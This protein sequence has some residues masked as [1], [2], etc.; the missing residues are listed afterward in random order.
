MNI[1]YLLVGGIETPG[2]R[3]RVLTY[4][5]FFEKYN[6]GYSCKYA[7]IR[8]VGK[9]GNLEHFLTLLK[10]GWQ[11]DIVYNYRVLLSHKELLTL[12]SASEN[13]IFDFDDAIFAIPPF[14]VPQTFTKSE[15]QRR[16]RETL[17]TSR[18][19]IAG[20]NFLKDYAEQYTKNVV[21]IPTCVDTN[22]YK[23]KE[24]IAECKPA[25][26]EAGREV[27]IGW[28]G[29]SAN[30]YYLNSISDAL[31]EIGKR[32]KN[33]ALKIVSD[34]FIDIP[35]IKVIKKN[36]QLEDEIRDLHSF[37]IGIMP[38]SEDTWS[39]GKCAFKAIQCMA[40]GL[41]VV[42]SRIGMNKEVIQ[43]GENGFL[44][45]EK[46]EWV[47]KLSYLIENYELRISMGQKARETVENKYSKNVGLGLLLNAF[48]SILPDSR[49]V[50]PIEGILSSVK[51]VERAKLKFAKFALRDDDISYFTKPS[52]LESLYKNIWDKI[53]ITFSVVPFLRGINEGMVP[54]EFRGI[55]REFP[56][57][58]NLKLVNFFREKILSNKADIILHGYSHKGSGESAEFES[59]FGLNEKIVKA[60]NYVENL[61]GVEVNTFMPPNGRISK[62]GI[63]AI[64]NNKL[65]LIGLYSF[66]PFRGE[67]LLSLNNI[68]N[69]AKKRF[70][71]IFRNAKDVQYPFIFDFKSHSELE[72]YEMTYTTT[73][74]ALKEAFNFVVEVRG[75]FCL[76]V[77]HWELWANKNM[78]E[79]FNSFMDYVLSCG[80]VEFCKVSDL[81]KEKS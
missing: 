78:R 41:P 24:Q 31:T 19:I 38:L 20:N 66:N 45:L 30:L 33:V 5:P 23:P 58:D 67:R 1:F 35:N 22:Y 11:K 8:A 81:F 53:P 71:Y 29:M 36:W 16:I 59:D 61:F 79:V 62:S 43:N 54:K 70:F 60:K 39:L 55:D 74:N 75:I 10:E 65:N 37:D 42:A 26:R 21:V 47:E 12:K 52:V 25:Y 73:F 72:S 27:I 28:I 32:Y 77:H 6:I 44:A 68:T 14:K 18:L 17:H 51:V 2:V 76:G 46:T 57:S 34:S 64:I 49:K 13:L 80:N 56:I 4:S 7:G 63:K 15:I 3:E 9:F 69:F 48:N 50:K 40:V